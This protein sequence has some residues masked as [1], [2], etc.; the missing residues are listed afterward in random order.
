MFL[1]VAFVFSKINTPSETVWQNISIWNKGRCIASFPLRKRNTIE[2][3]KGLTP[4]IRWNSNR[5]RAMRG[6]EVSVPRSGTCGKNGVKASG[7][8]SCA[9]SGCHVFPKRST[10]FVEICGVRHS[11]CIRLGWTCA[12]F[13]L[14]KPLTWIPQWHKKEPKPQ[15]PKNHKTFKDSCFVPLSIPPGHQKNC[16]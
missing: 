10:E 4:I 16:L 8:M 1:P 3:P 12:W 5:M 13:L 6:S 7:S 11:C 14:E 15:A 9:I 2:Q